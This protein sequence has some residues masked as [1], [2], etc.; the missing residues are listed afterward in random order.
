MPHA[1]VPSV[2]PM[3]SDRGNSASAQDRYLNGLTQLDQCGRR[4]CPEPFDSPISL[5]RLSHDPRARPTW[6]L[7]T[8]A[9]PSSW[10][11]SLLSPA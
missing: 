3:A 6:F 11:S 5:W 8:P 2:T 10:Q 9:R 1:I 7:E 4:I